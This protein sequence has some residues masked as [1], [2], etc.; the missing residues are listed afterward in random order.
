MG[1]VEIGTFKRLVSSIVES[2][3]MY[4]AE[5]WG[6]NRNVEI[7]QQ[8]QFK[9]ARLFFGVGTRHPRVSLLWELGDL[10]VVWI[11]KLRCAYFGSRSSPAHRPLLIAMVQEHYEDD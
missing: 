5:V 6:C 4:G 3:I 2:T 8:V 9:A 1:G 7:L 11:A 10:P